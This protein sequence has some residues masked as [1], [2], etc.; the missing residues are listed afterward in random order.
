MNTKAV[1]TALIVAVLTAPVAAGIGVASGVQNAESPSLILTSGDIDVEAG[2]TSTVTNAY[3]FEVES[4]GSGDQQLTEITGSVWKFPDR[5]VS[6]FS[7]SVDGQDVS[8]EVTERDRHYQVAVPVEGVSDGDTVTVTV[9]YE[10]TGPSGELK[11][12]VFVP[13][14]PT[15]GE[16]AVIDLQVTLPDG[17]QVQ[18]DAFPGMDSTEG[19]VATSELLHVPGFVSM[20]YGTSGGIGLNTAL[21]VLGIVIIVGVVGGWALLQRRR[22]TLPGGGADVS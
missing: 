5:S 9:T 13:D 21:S 20:N 22:A 16:D 4:A 2:E 10:V 17:Q 19:N 7:A 1:V 6:G 18:G 15:N 3:E 14:Y 8:A 12:P 11:T